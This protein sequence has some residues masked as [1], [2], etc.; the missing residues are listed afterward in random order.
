M[1]ESE[2]FQPRLEAA[3]QAKLRF[4]DENALPQLRENFRVFQ[5]LFENL[6][7]I[8]LRKAL[9]QEDPYR[10]E[11]RISEIEVPAKGDILELEKS[12]TLSQRLSAFHAQLEYLNT[13]QQFDMEFLDLKRIRRIIGLVRYINWSHVSATAPEAT[14][15]VLAETLG[16]IRPGSDNVSTGI[17]SS[18]LGQM[19]KLSRAILAQLKEILTVQRQNYKLMLRRQLLPT[20]GTTLESLYA[21]D[22][23]KAY[24]KLKAVFAATMKGQ[25]FYRDLVTELIQEEFSPD[26]AKLRQQSLNLLKITIKKPEGI[27]KQ[28]EH[29]G[30][31]LEAVRLMLPAGGHL[32]DALRKIVT[33]QETLQKSTQ[34]LG[35]K[36]R[37]WL[38]KRFQSRGPS[39]TVE[40]RYFDSRSSTS[41][42]ESLEYQK[43][44]E[45]VR[46]KSSLLDALNQPDSTSFTR[47][48]QASEQ[49]IDAFLKKNIEE[50]QL[51][52]RRLQGLNEVLREQ[53]PE[54]QKEQL[55]G[56]KI[57]MSGLKNCIIRANRRRYEYVALKE[58]ERRLKQLGV[59]E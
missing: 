17:I 12:E 16:K 25:P 3:L 54:G 55:K 57:E 7:N 56:I 6:Y 43:F 4:L 41:Q 58:E 33:N 32:K 44:V 40:L 49:Q 13:Y 34:G 53:A 59:V 5:S 52:Y 14:T 23:D 20:V 39:W 22:P 1:S 21:V 42:T 37:T 27:H 35:A 10:D 51:H 2:G 31:L 29:R 46:R 45:T 9:I 47:L 8:L 19:Q 15:A 28:P 36:L 30:L 48:S 18:S 11:H 24:Q 38:Q 50:L 26:G